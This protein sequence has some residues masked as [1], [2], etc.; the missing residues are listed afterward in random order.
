[1]TVAAVIFDVDGTLI[2]SVDQHAQSWV[3]A[4]RDFGHDRSFEEVRR[5]IGKGGDHLLPALLPRETVDRKGEEIEAH[6]S[7]LFKERFL[8][9]LKAFAG[10]RDLVERLVTDGK[11]VALGSSAKGDELEVYK[12]I[13]NVGDLLAAETSSSDAAQSKPDPD[14]FQAALERLGKPP[15]DVIVV[16]D[17]PYDAQAAGKAGMACIGLTC[18]GWSAEDLRQAGCRETYADPRELLAQYEQSSLR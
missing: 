18:G 17:T 7:R 5:Q 1:M 13:A 16:G 15:S 2:D 6:R 11:L 12:R 10:V 14:I 9:H 8:P 4:L 3:D